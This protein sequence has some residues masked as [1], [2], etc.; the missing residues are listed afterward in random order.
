MYINGIFLIQPWSDTYLHLAISSMFTLQHLEG[1]CW[2]LKY[3]IFLT[4]LSLFFSS[5]Q[6]TLSHDNNLIYTLSYFL[7]T[8]YSYNYMK[9]THRW[10][11]IPTITYNIHIYKNIISTNIRRYVL[12]QIL[13]I[14]PTIFHPAF[15][16]NNTWDEPLQVS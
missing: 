6:W 14:M 3:N 2:L 16:T 1:C 11:F 9:H 13:Y 12:L 10:M 5:P 15:L 4:P 7:Y 8:L